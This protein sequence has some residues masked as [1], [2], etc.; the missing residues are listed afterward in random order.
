MPII[1][2]CGIYMV[3]MTVLVISE[4]MEIHSMRELRTETYRGQI[5]IKGK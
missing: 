2:S 3:K 1:N 4:N 5:N